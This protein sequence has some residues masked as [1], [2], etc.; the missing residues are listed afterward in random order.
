MIPG[1]WERRIG[2]PTAP[3]TNVTPELVACHARTATDGDR[4]RLEF[5][6]RGGWRAKRTDDWST[7]IHLREALAR[8]VPPQLQR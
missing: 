7:E 1:A 8:R 3:P 5:R 2:R 4:E 6:A